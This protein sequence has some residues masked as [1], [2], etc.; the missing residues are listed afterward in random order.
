MGVNNFSAG[1]IASEIAA[2]RQFPTDMFTGSPET[3]AELQG[4]MVKF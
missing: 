4:S 3:I 2:L 1:S